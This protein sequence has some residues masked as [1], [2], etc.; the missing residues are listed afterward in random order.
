MKRFASENYLDP[1]VAYLLGMIVARG[2][3]IDSS[4]GRRVVIGFPARNLYAEGLSESYNQQEQIEQSLHKIKQRLEGLVEARTIVDTKGNQVELRFQFN[5]RNMSWRNIVYILSPHSSYFDFTIP[6]SIWQAPRE[7]KIEFLRGI[8]DCAG[9]IRQSNNYMGGKRRVYIEINNKNWLLPAQ[10]CRLLQVDLDVPVH[11]IQWG[12]PNTRAPRKLTQGTSWA[13]EHQIKIFSE[14]Y[15][16]IGF[17]VQYKQKLLAEFAEEDR[18]KTGN[19]RKCAVNHKIQRGRK[20]PKHPE[21]SN[22]LIPSELRGKHIDNYR[23]ICKLLGCS[24]RVK[25]NQVEMCTDD[26]DE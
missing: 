25:G 4:S 5:A 18:L 15:L 20:K 17:Y 9:F 22:K 13:K 21:E 7:S 19:L 11:C 1:D 26:V 12:H 6:A 3:L 23:Q 8:A 16:R 10:I 14:V 24:Q 2:K